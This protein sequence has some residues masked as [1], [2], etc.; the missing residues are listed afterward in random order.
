LKGNATVGKEALAGKTLGIYFSAHWCPPCRGFTPQLCKLYKECKDKGLPFEIV[1]STADRDEE[2][3]KNYFEEMAS[4][5]GD[6]LAIP[7]ADNKRRDALD[8]LFEVQGIPTF[9][10]VDENGQIINKNAR[11]AVTDGVDKFPWAPPLIGNLSRPEG[12]DESASVCVFAE[13][14]PANQQKQIITVLEPIA[15]KYVDKAKA[16]GED[17]DFLFFVASHSEGPVPKV[18]EMCKLGAAAALGHT[19]VPTKGETS[20]VGLVRSV[21]NDI[22]PSMAQMVLLDIPDNGGYY[23]SDAVE[24]TSECVEQFLSDYEGKKLERKQLEG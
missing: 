5:G 21:S 12:I 7:Y 6:W 24:I 10:I 1:F 11:G 2:S 8:S 20:P 17:P 13:A 22:A 18:R 15:K 14:L 4:N 9:V 19:V 16:A 3:F 23:V